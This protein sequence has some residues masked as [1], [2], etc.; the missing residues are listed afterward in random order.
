[1]NKIKD[2]GA[3]VYV[4]ILQLGVDFH[5]ILKQ[6]WIYKPVSPILYFQGVQIPYTT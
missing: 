6:A 5:F 2:Q 1:M 3:R 4:G